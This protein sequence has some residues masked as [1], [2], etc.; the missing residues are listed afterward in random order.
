MDILMSVQGQSLRNRSYSEM[1]SDTQE[2]I[3]F[4][5]NLSDD[6]KD[7]LVFAQFTQGE[8]SYNVYLDDDKSVYLPAEIKEGA[9]TLTLYGTGGNV[10][11]T[12]NS[13]TFRLQ[14]CRL[15]RD[16]KS[17]EIT[18]TL[19]EQL[20]N[21][22]EWGDALGIDHIGV[23][24]SKE[25][26]GVNV[27]TFYFTDGESQSFEVR[28]G[29]QGIQGEPGI[30]PTATVS[31]T[32]KTSTFEVTDASGT[33]KVDILDGTDGVSPTVSVS[34]ADG[35]TTVKITD[36]D[37]EHTAEIDDGVDGY[38]PVKGTDYFTTTDKEE[39]VSDVITLTIANN[40]GA[41]NSI[42]RGK[43]LGTSV[44][45]AQ[46][47]EISAGTFKD[48]YI[49]D[50]WTIGGKVYRIAAFDYYLNEGDSWFT[51]HHAVIVPDTIMYSAKMNDT[52]ITAG[53][54]VGSLMYTTN[55]ADAKTTIK[56]AFGEG[57]VASHR[58]YLY[59]TATNGIPTNG[60]W[61]DSDVELMTEIMVYGNS[62][63]IPMSNGSTASLNY[64]VEKSQLPLFAHNHLHQRIDSTYWLRDT[65]TAATFAIVYGSGN[66]DYYYASYSLGVRPAFCIS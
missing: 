12:T 45:D 8:D 14:K 42:Y 40:A 33:T 7:L 41:H 34:K 61:C 51:K 57:H 47:A 2:F 29:T 9:Y 26:A 30:S 66:A 49:G 65:C 27:V 20:V 15:V 17:T 24:E 59:N 13:R 19:Y 43:S 32:G 4:K 44:T 37:G 56:A 6:W 28:N 52:N 18:L 50:Y 16:G 48:L 63:C 39:L 54:Y 38:T 31:K 35:K 64:Q 55:L 53:G 21:R 25:D 58:V 46:Y 22:I 10:V 62:I 36:K 11:A 3:K 5:F 60:L 23:A 1:V